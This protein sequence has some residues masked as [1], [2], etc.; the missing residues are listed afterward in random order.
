MAESLSCVL[1]GDEVFV[2]RHDVRDVAAGVLQGPE[3]TGEEAPER[4]ELLVSGN[5]GESGWP[6]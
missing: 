4:T 2:F 6:V 3:R 5:E 1:E